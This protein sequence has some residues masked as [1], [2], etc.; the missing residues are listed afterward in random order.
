MGLAVIS[1]NTMG[2]L[3]CPLLLPCTVYPPALVTL[4]ASNVTKYPFCITELRILDVVR[5]PRLAAISSNNMGIGCIGYI[6]PRKS[7]TQTPGG[8]LVTLFEKSVTPPAL[9]V[10][11]LENL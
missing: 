1:T 3:Y 10:A 9:M 5:Q 11:L 6:A 7:V 4:G 2:L 8:A